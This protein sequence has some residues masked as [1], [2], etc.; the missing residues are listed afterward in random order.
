M[1]SGSVLVKFRGRTAE[2]LSEIYGKFQLKITRSKNENG[3]ILDF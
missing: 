1:V 3:L 2:F